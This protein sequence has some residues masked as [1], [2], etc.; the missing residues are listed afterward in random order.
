ML[1]TLSRVRERHGGVE[2]YLLA[3]GATADDLAALRRRL[4]ED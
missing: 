2:A 1:A 3:G 4:T